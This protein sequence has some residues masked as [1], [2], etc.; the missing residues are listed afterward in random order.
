[1]LTQMEDIILKFNVKKVIHS[2][3]SSKK[4]IYETIIS[5][6]LLGAIYGI[7]TLTHM[8]VKPQN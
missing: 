3:K 6:E 1:M 5:S 8:E 7:Y 2:K 4:H